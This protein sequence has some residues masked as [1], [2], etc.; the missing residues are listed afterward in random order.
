M[1]DVEA[2]YVDELKRFTKT[3]FDLDQILGT[4]K[5]LKYTR[6]V[7]RL[8]TMEWTDPSEA[9]VRHFATQVYDGVQTKAVI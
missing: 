7:L 1:L 5:D 8:L 2:I 6:E 9:F 4:A 3:S